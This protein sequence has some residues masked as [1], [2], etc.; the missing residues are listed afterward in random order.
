MIIKKLL[1]LN[2]KL[3]LTMLRNFTTFLIFI[4]LCNCK[5][6]KLNR[7]PVII[8]SISFLKYGQEFDLNNIMTGVDFLNEI[9]NSSDTIHTKLRANIKDVCSKK[10]CWITLELPNQEELMVRFKDYSF[11]VPLESSGE[12]IIN[13]IAFNSYTSVEDL[14]HYAEDSGASFIDI[15]TIIEPKV[16]YN[17]IAEGILLVQ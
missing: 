17:F 2:L 12:A 16:T 14:R 4:L 1:Y 7:E 10:G 3:S 13:G 15:E 9:Q 8:D 5:N 6:N 11:F